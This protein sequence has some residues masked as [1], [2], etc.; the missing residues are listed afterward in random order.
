MIKAIDGHN[1]I[2]KLLNRDVQQFCFSK[3]SSYLMY[4]ENFVFGI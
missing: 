3:L 4:F 1:V 2:R